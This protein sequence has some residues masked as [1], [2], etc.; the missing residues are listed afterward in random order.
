MVL[1]FAAGV[2]AGR[3][4]LVIEALDA[5]LAR[6]RGLVSREYFRDVDERWVK[7]LVWASQDDLDASAGLEDDPVVAELF[8]HFDSEGVAYAVCERFEPTTS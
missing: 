3:Q 4:A 8:A 2:D 7:H 5:H 1:E 6:C